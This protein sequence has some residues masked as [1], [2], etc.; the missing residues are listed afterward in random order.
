MTSRILVSLLALVLT[1]TVHAAER[2]SES[3]AAE[4]RD[5]AMRGESVAWDFV[6]ELTTRVGPRPAGSTAERAAAE[7]SAH[8]LKSLGFENVRIEPFPMTA[9]VRGT[10][11]VEI[12]S[13]SPQPVVATALGGSPATPSNGIEGEVVMFATLD[14]L[15]AAAPGSLNGRIAML[16]RRM[17][18]TQ[19]GS[20]Y[21]ASSAMRR[22]GPNEAA[23]RGAIGFVIRSLATGGDR[24]AHAGAARYDGSRFSIPSFA[25]SEPDAD[26]ILRLTQ[27]GEKVRLRL[28]STAS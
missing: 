5:E 13:P 2:S 14:D 6:S 9:W 1:A 19:D 15:R 23:H 16:T 7:W 28:D 24:F 10:E 20:G 3:I 4:L 27:L 11:H 12:T 22:D 8:K 26:Q 25:I 18:A 21:G 17:P